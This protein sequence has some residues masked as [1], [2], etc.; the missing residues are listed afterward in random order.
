MCVLL[1]SSASTEEI[2]GNNDNETLT[3]Q[4]E[5]RIIP[6]IAKLNQPKTHERI[7]VLPEPEKK[8]ETQ[9]VKPV[10]EFGVESNIKRRPHKTKYSITHPESHVKEK[11]TPKN[12]DDGKGNYRKSTSYSKRSDNNRKPHHANRI[13]P[14]HINTAVFKK[15]PPSHSGVLKP[16]KDQK[17][18]LKLQNLPPN[19]KEVPET[20]WFDNVGNYNYGIL[21]SDGLTATPE[22][23]ATAPT[24]KAEVRS[25][26]RESVVEVLPPKA[27]FKSSF[28]DPKQIQPVVHDNKLGAFLYKTEVH[29]P[30]YRSHMYPPMI[31]YGGAAD[32][33]IPTTKELPTIHKHVSTSKKQKSPPP[34]KKPVE[35]KQK[36]T[37][38][39]D[40]Y[41][42]EEDSSEDYEEEDN[43]KYEGEAPKNQKSKNAKQ[44][45]SESGQDEGDDEEDDEEGDDGEGEESQDSASESLESNAPRFRFSFD[46]G[47]KSGSYELDDFD[48]AWAKFGYGPAH[49]RSG[50]AED[51]SHESSETRVEPVRIKFYHEKKE[52]TTSGNK[53][54]RTT[55][56]KPDK[57][58]D[59][60]DEDE[61]EQQEEATLPP[62]PR[63]PLRKMVKTVSGT[64]NNNP[65]PKRRNSRKPISSQPQ[66]DDAPQAGPDD[67]KY[68][69]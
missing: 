49:D 29:Y 25:S 56:E 52:E 34:A 45:A 57:Y 42:E 61:E 48:K 5:T 15:K 14:L 6:V 23:T 65:N 58:E 69:Q 9:S 40:D 8:V 4:T 47:G 11:R 37:D 46:E 3:V 68:F 20:S 19:P 55:T 51:G 30:S 33:S 32:A 41:D 16:T 62:P 28:R 38:D 17:E 27:T 2:V 22:Y 59:E 43:D 18:R 53:K 63:W 44:Q 64:I 10:K 66:A 36:Q 12:Y 60:D 54:S 50:S 21:H 67:L 31:T 7:M 35:T 1:A 26:S 13:Q 39:G 24:T